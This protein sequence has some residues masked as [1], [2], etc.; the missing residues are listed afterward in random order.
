MAFKLLGKEQ[1]GAERLR[2]GGYLL[3]SSVLVVAVVGC[4]WMFV[5]EM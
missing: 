1:S 2:L 3:S 4:G 5:T